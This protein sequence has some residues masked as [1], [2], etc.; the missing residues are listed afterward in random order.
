[1]KKSSKETKPKKNLFRVDIN[2]SYL[3]LTEQETLGLNHVLAWLNSMHS[4]ELDTG[5]SYTIQRVEDMEDISD[6]SE[7]YNVYTDI[8]EEVNPAVCELI[9]ELNLDVSGLIQRLKKLGYSITKK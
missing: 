1:M 8:E 3:F 6:F 7:D 5:D 4:G 2:L 9:K